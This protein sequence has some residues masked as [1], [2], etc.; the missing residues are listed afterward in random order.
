VIALARS[1]KWRTIVGLA[2]VWVAVVFELQF[3]WGLLFLFWIAPDIVYGA[4]Y[5]IEPLS[6]QETPLL[7]WAVVATWLL[8][9]AYLL[10]PISSRAGQAARG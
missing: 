3:V 10:W 8:L 5:F 6:R 1:L 4:T 9:S 7:F 2:M